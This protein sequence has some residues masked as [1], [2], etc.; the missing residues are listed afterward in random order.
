LS[1][2]IDQLDDETLETWESF[3][4]RFARAA[5]LFLAKYL[6]TMVLLDDPGFRGSMRDFINQG[7]KLGLIDNAEHWLEIRSLRN[8][9]AYEYTEEDLAAFFKQ[10]KQECPKLLKLKDQL[11]AAKTI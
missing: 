9:A 7:E 1:L 3:A 10:L 11:N 4:A 5:D 8:I 2:V 6:R